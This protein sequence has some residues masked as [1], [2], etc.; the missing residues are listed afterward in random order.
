MNQARKIKDIVYM[1]QLVMLYIIIGFSP[2]IRYLPAYTAEVAKE[3]AWVSPFVAIIPLAFTIFFLHK[4]YSKSGN[5]S[6]FEIII[7]IFGKYAGNLIIFIHL[8]WVLLLL[9]F[10]VRLNGE[11]LASTVYPNIRI[12]FFITVTLIAAAYVLRSGAT[13]LA[14]MGEFLTP[15]LLLLYTFI[16]AFLLPM[17]RVDALLPVYLNDAI[18]IL[19]ASTG[20]LSLFSYAI[21]IL[22]LSENIK[23][24]E[25]TGW[26]LS[27]AAIVYLIMLVV[28]L[29][30]IV[31][32]LGSSITTRA[33]NPFLIVVKQI[34]ILDTIENIESIVI[35][36]WLLS[37]AMLITTMA[38]IALKIMKY[39]F[40]LSD[41]NRLINI[42]LVFIYIFS[43][44]I[45]S[46]RVEIDA[47]ASKVLIYLNPLLGFGVPALLFVVGKIRK[48]I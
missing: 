30:M 31:G 10:Y 20:T 47:F 36:M 43:L 25:K 41:Q 11:R 18:P 48:K 29:I 40:K 2:A 23:G 37:D 8:I 32:V 17:V 46:D 26:L 39:L 12:T 27:K 35:A 45:T 5:K 9:A 6:T 16:A 21:L 28:L 14:R 7:N 19:K 4:I 38:Y 33:S 34:S 22:M 3:A 42:F 24:K 44:G 15:I 1:R 13:A